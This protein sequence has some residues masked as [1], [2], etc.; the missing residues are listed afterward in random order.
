MRLR[1]ALA[2]LALFALAAPARAEDSAPSTGTPDARAVRVA[3]DVMKALG[4]RQKW[5]ALPGLT[6]RFQV[7][8]NDTVRSTRYHA[9]DKHTGWHRVGYHTAAGDSFLIIE[10]VGTP[11]GMAWANGSP[12]EGDSLQKLITRAMRLWTN[13]MYWML[14]PYKMRDAGVKLVWDSEKKV[15]G[16]TYDVIAM[17]FDHV[18]QTPEDHY[19]VDVNRANHRVESW[20]MVLQGD[21]PPPVRWSWEG[22]SRSGDLWFPTIHHR[23]NAHTWVNTDHVQAVTQFPPDTF[24]KP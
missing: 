12:I 3:D 22:W 8:L 16:K 19:W 6:W 4:G 5:D 13:D 20:S 18:G 11:E 15:D 9:W 21:Q 7:I 2:A 17:T 10:K 14:M 24:T 23:E 1:L